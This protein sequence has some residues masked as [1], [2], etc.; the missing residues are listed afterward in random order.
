MEA[1]F[2][3]IETMTAGNKGTSPLDNRFVLL[4]KYKGLTTDVNL[5]SRGMM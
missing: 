2:Q 1:V 4:Q 3:R 5:I